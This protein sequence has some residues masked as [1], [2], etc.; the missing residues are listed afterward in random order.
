MECK[1]VPITKGFVTDTESCEDCLQYYQLRWVPVDEKGADEYSASIHQMWHAQTLDQ[2]SFGKQ[3][4][5]KRIRMGL[6]QYELAEKLNEEDE[7]Q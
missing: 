4:K 5:E 3:L 2:S 7:R 6:T 1:H